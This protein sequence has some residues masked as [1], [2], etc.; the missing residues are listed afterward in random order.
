[1]KDGGKRMEN[2]NQPAKFSLSF[3]TLLSSQPDKNGKYHRSMKTLPAVVPRIQ[4]PK[5]RVTHEQIVQNSRGLDEEA[6]YSLALTPKSLRCAF[7]SRCTCLLVFNVR[8]VLF[9]QH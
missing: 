2:K 4:R 8:R 3:L 7:G 6:A 5:K 1:M 9:K